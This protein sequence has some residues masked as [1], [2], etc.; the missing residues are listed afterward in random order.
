MEEQI[1]QDVW[2]QVFALTCAQPLAA[3]LDDLAQKKADW[4]AK[5]GK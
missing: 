1:Y 5:E 4:A 2:C 3:G